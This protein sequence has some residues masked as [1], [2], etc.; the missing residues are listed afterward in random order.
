VKASDVHIQVVG[1][2]A[3]SQT[4]LVETVEKRI[5]EALSARGGDEFISVSLTA[6]AQTNELYAIVVTATMDGQ[7]HEF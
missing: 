5:S 3:R 2:S 7:S 6:S 4:G 1:H